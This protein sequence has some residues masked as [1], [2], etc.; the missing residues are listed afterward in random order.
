[1][2]NYK[3]KIGILVLVM[4][5][6]S[7]ALVD[8]PNLKISGWGYLTY[9]KIVSSLTEIGAKDMDLDGQL[10]SDFDAGLKAEVGLSD[11]VKGRF[12]IG[13]STAFMMV[14]KTKPE[15]ELKRR[16]FVPYLI[17]AAIE[18]TKKFN[19]NTFFTE[20]GYFPIKYNKDVRN[21]GEYLFR[22]NS[23]PN[24]VVNGFELS[25]KEK[26][27]GWHGMY[28]NDFTENSW[29]RGD[30]FFHT[31]MSLYPLYNFSLSY[32]LSA[33]LINLVELGTG[34]SHQHL[35]PINKSQTTPG[36]N[37]EK[38]NRTTAEFRKV[39]YIGPK[40]DTIVYTFSGAKAMGRISLDP[41]ALFNAPIFG[42]ED[43]KIYSEVAVLG[44]KDY[45]YWFDN[46]LERM[47]L[48]VGFNVPTFKILDVLS[49]E[50]Q[51]WKYPWSN[52]SENIWKN[53]GPVPY[54][55]N[56]SSGN[57]PVFEE[58]DTT[59][60]HDDDLRWS[61]YASKKIKDRV[62]ICL[63]FACDNMS[64]TVFGGPPPSF[65][66]YTEV[67]PRKQDWYWASRVQFYF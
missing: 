42:L 51:Y 54:M 32:M 29:I 5:V 14:D 59:R 6:F 12:H 25:D 4:S 66:K 24:V 2:D 63:Q 36:D 67:M 64:R 57:F 1:M 9:G 40:G 53:G 65:S 50:L 45:P 11:N 23:Y 44:W 13:L 15:I 30:L 61:I 27:V 43:L 35:I 18:Y 56:G 62:R 21:L 41:K 20:F 46:R 39:G 31:E 22:S 58:A 55:T 38:Y 19:N 49:I 17:D 26:I 48:M 37:R 7:F 8:A 28:Q 34:V 3:N 10:F 60:L 33:R 16:R 52:N 47:P